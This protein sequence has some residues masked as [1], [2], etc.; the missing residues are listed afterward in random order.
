[1]SGRTDG[2]LHICYI[3]DA[4]NIH[5]RRWT[6]FFVEQGH[7]V[8]VLTDEGAKISGVE[9][10]DIG[11]CLAPVHVPGL[12]ALSQILKKSLMM[13]KLVRHI[14]PD[15]VHGHYAT[16]Y[17]Y[18]AAATGFQPLVQTVH[19][20][21]VLV[22]AAGS[23]LQRWF[24]RR[25]LRKALLITAV[26]AQMR[27]R[28]VD[29]GIPAERVMLHQYG[30]DTETFTPAEET[31]V[32][33]PFRII[34]TRML[35]WKYNIQHLVRAAPGIR[36]RIPGADIVLVGDGPD[37]EEL[38]EMIAG[39]DVG[40]TVSLA[41]RA[42]HDEIPALL[43]SATVYVS[44]SVT[45]GTSLSLLEAMAAGAFPVVTDIPGNR[46]WIT[47]GENGFLVEVDDVEALTDRIAR[48]YEQ[49]DLR[50]RVVAHNLDL[51]RRHG[52]YTTNM[53]LMESVYRRIVDGE[54]DLLEDIQKNTSGDIES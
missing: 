25:A 47:D 41:G 23:G 5:I 26:T 1:M 50:E 28:V 18:L 24:V 7:H 51:V 49:P 43:Q 11:D 17:G 10:Y 54:P 14:E 45:D 12:S 27:Q 31:A 3:G 36:D 15:I 39:L 19:G 34:S 9:V 40:D 2:K 46:E 8:S 16:N 48:V 21:D 22:D 32:K 42:S 13:K 38:E 33:P 37:K 6:H 30:V 35:E 20:S 29:M 4:R 44:T 52:D 53:T